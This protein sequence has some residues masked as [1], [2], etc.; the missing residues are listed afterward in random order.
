MQVIDAAFQ[1]ADYGVKIAGVV[2]MGGLLKLGAAF[3]PPAPVV[4]VLCLVGRYYPRLVMPATD[5]ESTYDAAFGDPEWARTTRRDPKIAMALKPTLGAAA[6]TLG[7]GDRLR[8]RAKDFPVPFLAVHGR[9]DVRTSPEVMLEF[10]DRMGPERG[11]M[12]MIDTDGHQLLQDRP[13]VT[14]KVTA[15]IREWITTQAASLQSSS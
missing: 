11:T 2:T 4:S 7:T 8:P 3:L 9:R 1:G 6:A 15:T 13:E 12:E 14:A 5:F 10:V